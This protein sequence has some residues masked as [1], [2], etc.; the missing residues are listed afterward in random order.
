MCSLNIDQFGEDMTLALRND[1]P[2]RTKMVQGIFKRKLQSEE[3][4][5]SYG[6]QKSL[7]RRKTNVS[8]VLD[9]DR[10]MTY[11]KMEETQL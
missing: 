11:L 4:S 10:Q 6:N 3:T 2:H 7:L 1:D 9:K 5:R 8:E